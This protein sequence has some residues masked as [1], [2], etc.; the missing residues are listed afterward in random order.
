[1]AARAKAEIDNIMTAI[2]AGIITPSTKV[3]LEEAEARL[4]EAERQVEEI[5][6][7]QPAQILPR[8]REIHRSMVEQL[9][10]IEE[11]STVKEAIRDIVGE[12]RLI[13][14]EG[15]LWAEIKQGGMAALSQLLVVAGIGFEP[16]TF[17]L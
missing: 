11:V 16:M 12:I 3:A 8:A 4:Q 9:E 10:Q 5:Q 7:F 13:P 17:G 14:E 2:K 6:R 1:M 15:E